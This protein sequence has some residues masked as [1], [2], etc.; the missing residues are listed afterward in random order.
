MNMT[1]LQQHIQSTIHEIIERHP[2]A[3]LVWCDPRGDWAPLLRAALRG[4]DIPLVEVETRIAGQ[5]G[6]LTDHA[7]AG[8][9]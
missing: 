4:S 5:L 8:A 9:Y 2:R 3:W 1:T 6:G 7:R